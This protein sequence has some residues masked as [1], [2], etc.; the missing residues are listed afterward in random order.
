MKFTE[1]EKQHARST[2]CR[3]GYDWTIS[4]TEYACKVLGHP[5]LK[6]SDTSNYHKW[7]EPYPRRCYCGEVGY[8]SDGRFYA[9]KSS[10]P[11]LMKQIFP[12]GG[13]TLG[14]GWWRD[15]RPDY[16]TTRVS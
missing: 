8:T 7:A 3:I 2:L 11:E 9:N 16:G 6:E 12:D 4:D 5:E 10:H 13:R 1:C 15:E 14:R